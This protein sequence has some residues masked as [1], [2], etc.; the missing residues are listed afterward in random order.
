[1]GSP[2]EIAVMFDKAECHRRLQ[3]A[4]VALPR[5]LGQVTSFE[6][7][8]ARMRAA[9]CARVFAKLS[10]GSSASGAVA[11]RTDGRRHQA[12]TTVEMV[13]AE[14]GMHLYNSRRVRVHEDERDIGALVDA[15]APHGLHVEEWIPKAG[16]AGRTL[17]LRVVVIAG[18]PRHV[19]VRLSRTPMTNLHLLND[20][21]DAGA[22]RERLGEARWAAAMETCAR[23]GACFPASLHVG[24]DL[25]I[26]SDF[27][28]HAVLEANAF[29]D[30]LPGILD[31][32]DDTYTAEIRS[33]GERRRA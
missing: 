8:R 12:M 32:G 26:S 5:A 13:P 19:A 24:V 22:V 15:L 25:L 2:S 3:D 7:L 23:A 31:G 21:G 14:D 4:G 1:M 18:R 28:G 29:G 20:R 33:V 6:E 17:D 10:H 11:Y 30:L 9:G 16:L 27:Q